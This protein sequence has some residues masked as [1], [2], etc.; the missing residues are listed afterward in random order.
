M[1]DVEPSETDLGRGV[2]FSRRAFFVGA[3]LGGTAV[4]VAATTP[5]AARQWLFKKM[6]QQPLEQRVIAEAKSHRRPFWRTLVESIVMWAANI[7]LGAVVDR[8]GLQHGGRAADGEL[9]AEQV[10]D[11][12]VGLYAQECWI[13]PIVEEG[14]FRLFPSSFFVEEQPP[15]IDNHWGTGLVSA[16]LFA[17][18]HNFSKPEEGKIRL[19]FDSV[20][21][22]QFVLGVYCWYA[23]RQGGFVHAA[24]SHVL[25]NHLCEAYWHLY[26]KKALAKQ[27]AASEEASNG[28]QPENGSVDDSEK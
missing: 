25:Y 24:G 20:P 21:L 14:F 17:A 8:L 7:G 13:L 3:I 28:E 10:E 2:T 6:D 27:I 22:E 9:Y 23:Q 26:E 16:A 12:P 4:A 15:N 19:H 1:T 18:I 11:S 5:Q